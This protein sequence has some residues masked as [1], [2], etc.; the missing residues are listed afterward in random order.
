MFQK[1]PM[2][3]A[4]VA[5]HNAFLSREEADATLCLLLSETRWE[6][7]RVTVHG[8]TWPQPR[9]VAWHGSADYSYSGLQLAP[10]PMTPALETLRSRIEDTLCHPF[11]S[12]LLNRYVAGQNHGIGFHSDNEPELG[13]QPTIAMLTL[14]DPRALE[15]QPKSWTV[16]QARRI[17]TPHGSLLVMSGDTQR[18]W[19]HGVH[20]QRGP[21]DRVT[22]TFRNIVRSPNPGHAT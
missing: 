8:K 20:K 11:N 5:I 15:F 2:K 14:G 22:L 13:T 12:V 1:P 9:L 7:R 10:T 16:D 3:G 4:T 17:P 19:T 21:A 6:Q 18:N